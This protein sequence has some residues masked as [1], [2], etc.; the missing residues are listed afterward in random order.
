MGRKGSFKPVTEA[1]VF[2][3]NPGSFLAG[4]V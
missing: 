3:I 4:S 1:K 2:R